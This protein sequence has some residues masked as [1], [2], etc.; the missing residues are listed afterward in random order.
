MDDINRMITLTLT[1][2]GSKAFSKT[3][4]NV[5]EQ[6]ENLTSYDDQVFILKPFY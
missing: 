2:S 6:S 5:V 1:I 4:K 3:V